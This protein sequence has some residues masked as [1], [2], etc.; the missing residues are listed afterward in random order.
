MYQEEM[1][2]GPLSQP[3]TARSF[4][5]DLASTTVDDPFQHPQRHTEDHRRVASSVAS[6]RG[7]GVRAT[8]PAVNAAPSNVTNAPEA[9]A[10][11]AD[12]ETERLLREYLEQTE[13]LDAARNADRGRQSQA[14]KDKLEAK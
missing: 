1:L 7:G 4:V 12:E 2:R 11:G 6:P 14:L 13:R 10:N 3:T 9:A 5:P 8:V